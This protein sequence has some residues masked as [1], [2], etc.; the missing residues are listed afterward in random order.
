M[1]QLLLATRNPG[2]VHEMK[3]ILGPLNLNVIS[4]LDRTG[5]PDVVE[6]GATFRSNAL[7]KARAIFRATGIPSLADDSGLEVRG[8]NMRPGV[9]SARFAGEPASYEANNAK[10]LAALKNVQGVGRRARFRCVVAFVAGDL[11]K[12]AEGVCEGTIIAEPRG[13]GGFGYD[14]LF[15]PLGHDATFAELSPS[16][17]NGLSHRARA[18]AR[19]RPVLEAFFS[20]G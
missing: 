1:K 16:V 9:R 15:V 18:L 12:T 11:E 20:A 5:I 10:L 17:K 7:K 4:L 2:K 3:A 8:L 14:P 13:Q 6:D 19:I